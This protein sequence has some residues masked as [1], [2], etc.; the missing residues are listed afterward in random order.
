MP[1]RRKAVATKLSACCTLQSNVRKAAPRW[2]ADLKPLL[3]R[4]SFPSW[5]HLLHNARDLHLEGSSGSAEVL[6]ECTAQLI[7]DIIN[8]RLVL[9]LADRPKSASTTVFFSFQ[10]KEMRAPNG[11]AIMPRER[12]RCSVT[13]PSV[14]LASPA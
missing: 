11:K 8:V 13:G 9:V 4:A 6:R 2:S 12:P 5:L 3:A 10:H 1:N 7:C 14:R